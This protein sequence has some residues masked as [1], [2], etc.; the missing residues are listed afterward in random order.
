MAP[1]PRVGDRVLVPSTGQAGTLRFLGPTHFRPGVWAGVELDAMGSGKNDGSVAGV[2]YF[3]CPP[4]TGLF[5]PGDK[6]QPL[7]HHPPPPA[8]TASRNATRTPVRPTP[9]RANVRTPLGNGTGFGGG[10][11]GHHPVPMP[12]A[13]TPT[14]RSRQNSHDSG[15]SR[16]RFSGSST[17]SAGWNAPPQQYTQAARRGAPGTATRAG[18]TQSGGRLAAPGAGGN[19]RGA[20]NSVNGPVAGSSTASPSIAR[21]SK[22]GFSSPGPVPHSSGGMPTSP[23]PNGTGPGPRAR[24]ALS[25]NPNAAPAP[26]PMPQVQPTKRLTLSVLPSPLPSADAVYSPGFSPTS[27]Q[28]SRSSSAIGRQSPMP[29]PMPHQHSSEYPTPPHTLLHTLPDTPFNA[30]LQAAVARSATPQMQQRAAS[31][32]VQARGG[33]GGGDPDADARAIQDLKAKTEALEAENRILQLEVQQAKATREIHGLLTPGEADEADLKVKDLEA[34]LAHASL[35]HQVAVA[36]L[37]AAHAK[38]VETLELVLSELQSTLSEKNRAITEHSEKLAQLQVELTSRTIMASELDDISQT[39][40]LLETEA[41]HKQLQAQ[42]LENELAASQKELAARTDAVAALERDKRKAETDMER[43]RARVQVLEREL[44][45]KAHWVDEYMKEGEGR[46]EQVGKLHADIKAKQDRIEHLALE[47]DARSDMLRKS[48]SLMDEITAKAETAAAEV[49]KWSTA[50]KALEADAAALRA[51]VAEK[52]AALDAK[53]AE[54]ARLYEKHEAALASVADR[55]AKLAALAAV[56]SENA[57]LKATVATLTGD[58]QAWA[59]REDDR[60]AAMQALHA[61]VARLQAAVEAHEA[62]VAD[63]TASLAERDRLV[64]TLERDLASRKQLVTQLQAEVDSLASQVNDSERS[65]LAHTQA[66]KRLEAQ[67]DARAK[68]LAEVEADLTASTDRAARAETSVKEK[69]KALDAQTARV[70]QLEDELAEAREKATVL[71]TQQVA[72]LQRELD[73]AKAAASDLAA[74]LESKSDDLVAAKALAQGR[75]QELAQAK[76]SLSSAEQSLESTQARANALHEQLVA[77]QSAHN[78]LQDEYTQALTRT[79]DAG[80]VRSQAAAAE[81]KA[82]QLAAQLADRD[83]RVAELSAEVNAA[84]QHANDARGREK[85]A[86]ARIA[87]LEQQLRDAEATAAAKERAAEELENKVKHLKQSRRETMSHY[88]ESIDILMA[89]MMKLQAKYDQVTSKPDPRRLSTQS[90]P[91]DH[92]EIGVVSPNLDANPYRMSM[93]AAVS[94]SAISS[95]VEGG[96]GWTDDITMYPGDETEVDIDPSSTAADEEGVDG[97]GRHH[98]TAPPRSTS[99]SAAVNSARSRSRARGSF[100]ALAGGKT[101]SMAGLPDEYLRSFPG[102]P[103]AAAVA[104]RGSTSDAGSVAGSSPRESVSGQQQQQQPAMAMFRF[105]E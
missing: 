35:A 28:F 76:A 85:A 57:D 45:D 59:T 88:M 96:D 25:I 89:D 54:F 44:Q 77:L 2:S 39:I 20:R 14:A 84:Q 43:H 13:P 103:S 3:R 47:L 34:Q 58:K 94:D 53:A 33:G 7:P 79:T 4:E 70:A 26:E 55:D 66:I 104:H 18:T 72:A 63:L 62:K 49:T 75:A 67:V 36:E 27:S 90:S 64:A 69:S 24:K 42:R 37:E 23:S 12:L 74:Q 41:H 9:M 68:A 40:S 52:T 38:Q 16:S 73:A 5:V 11:G 98:R 29:H 21:L 31:P 99:R 56:E 95:S 87:D 80:L 51:D 105:E 82:A 10:A 48:Q 6:V 17:G 8:P 19:L 81:A 32:L 61:D 65:S 97:R 83:A 78:A 50:A 71:S 93:P 60:R 15:S 46:V 1:T 92:H 30:R 22:P 101:V 102:V 91:G 100:D 86:N